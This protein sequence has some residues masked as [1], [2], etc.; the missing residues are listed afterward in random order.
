MTAA[1]F[2]GG[3]AEPHRRAIGFNRSVEQI[4]EIEARLRR[5]LSKNRIG[6]SAAEEIVRSI[7][8]FAFYGYPQSHPAGFALPAYAS[9]YLKVHYPAEFP[10]LLLECQPMGH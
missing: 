8:A 7:R 6:G 4:S 10:V 5:R 9:A 1:S 3:Q 2:T